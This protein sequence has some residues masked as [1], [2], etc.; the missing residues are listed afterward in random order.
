M[1]GTQRS[2]ILVDSDAIFSETIVPEVSVTQ[3]LTQRAA[4]ITNWKSLQGSLY[5]LCEG[6]KIL[7]FHG[8]DYEECCL[9]GCYTIWLL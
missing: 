3:L 5:I 7:G 6:C 2:V 9:L 8:A 4:V 1:P